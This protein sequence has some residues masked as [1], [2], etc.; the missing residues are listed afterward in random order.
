VPQPGFFANRALDGIRAA[1]E[2]MFPENDLGVPDWRATRLV[3]RTLEYI[4]ELPPAQRR[5]IMALFVV[6]ELIG[7]WLLFRPR[8]F[9]KLTVALREEAVRGWRASKVHLLRMLGD[10]LK[11]VLTM[12]YASHP[13]VMAYLGE[14]RSCENRLDDVAMRVDRNALGAPAQRS[15]LGT[16]DV[17]ASVESEAS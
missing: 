13:S 1:A 17:A 6:L 11:A 9:S 14:Y 2:S 5:L 10:S 4:G 7:G 8:R 15:T 16:A 12:V 3:D